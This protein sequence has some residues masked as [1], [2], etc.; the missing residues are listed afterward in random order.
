[1]NRVTAWGYD[2]PGNVKTLGAS[3][4]EYDAENRLWRRTQTVTGRQT[5]YTYDGEGRRVKAVDGG[6]ATYYVYDAMDNLAAEYGQPGTGGG[7]QYLTA[8]HLGST[9]IVTGTWPVS[10]AIR[11]TTTRRWRG[12]V[13]RDRRPDDR[14]RLEIQSFWNSSADDKVTTLTGVVLDVGV[15]AITG[16]AAKGGSLTTIGTIDVE[17]AAE[18]SLTSLAGEIRESGLHPAAVN[19][20][21]VAVG[22]NSQGQLFAGSSNGFDRGQRGAA[23]ARGVTCVSCKKGAHAEENLMR[24]VPDLKQVG[25]SRRSPCGPSEHNCAGQLADQG[26]RVEN[27]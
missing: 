16:G 25:T 4:G 18:Q 8:D 14:T 3:T 15:A 23:Q 1:M 22:E 12:T 2:K 13:G 17:G 5:V 11:Y 27:K 9:R 7:T 24:E 6:V 21:T 20:R 26:V 10:S 19:N